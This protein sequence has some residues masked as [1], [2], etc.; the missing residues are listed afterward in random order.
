MNSTISTA[1]GIAYIFQFLHHETLSLTSRSVHSQANSPNLSLLISSICSLLKNGGKWEVLSS[2][3]NSTKLNETLVEKIILNLKEPTDAKNALLFFH[4]SSQH[5]QR[6]HSLKSYCLVVHILVRANLLIDA[7][8]LLESSITKNSAP[9]SSKNLVFGTLLSTYEAAVPDPRVFEVLVQTYLKMSFL[10]QAIDACCYLGDHGII[11]SLLTFN[12]MLHV[13]QSLNRSDLAWKV[14]ENMLEKRVYPN[15]TS[16]QTMV[17]L[18]CKEGSLQRMLSLLD[19]IHGKRCGPGVL[20]NM[21]LV[22]WMFEEDRIEHGFILLRRM[23]Q[24][25]LILDDVMNSLIIFA[26]CKTGKFNE[27]MKA[28]DDMRNRGCGSNAFVYTC[29]IHAHANEGLIEEALRL[30]E[31]MHSN[32]LKPYDETYNY[33]IEGS[34]K[35]G[36]LEESLAFYEKMMKEGFVLSFSTFS[37]IVGRL[38]DNGKVEKADEIFTALSDRGFVPNENIYC[39][40]INGFGRIGKDQ[41]IITLYHEM[42][43]RGLDLGPQVYAALVASLSQ[44]GKMKEAEKFLNMMEGKSLFPNRLMYDALINGYLKKGDAGR[45]MHF[46]NELLSKIIM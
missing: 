42:Q 41:K 44:C 39:N 12:R 36:R 31:E 4:W 32:G 23:L 5:M 7:Q 33:L 29:F 14:Y 21:A 37:E 46:S 13:A 24:K 25:N 3:F 18:M 35:A 2:T 10:D 11:L 16:V 27:A 20:V 45:A 1:R 26:Y 34:A 9:E 15:Q 28:Y 17:S 8:A 38:C 43:Y 19:R 30:L 40:L 6:Q 22:L